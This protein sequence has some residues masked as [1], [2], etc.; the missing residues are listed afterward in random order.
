[1]VAV[2]S[3]GLSLES[4]I[5]CAVADSRYPLCIVPE[6]T[7]ECLIDLAN[8]RFKE[9]KR[10]TERFRSLLKELSSV[11]SIEPRRRGQEGDEWED[12]QRRRE[13]KKA[14][15]LVRS[16]QRKDNTTLVKTELGV[17]VEPQSLGED[18]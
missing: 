8:E 18:D 2:R 5:G 6:E 15:G 3:M 12:P 11:R 16:Q 17:I 1:M 4:I 13:R 10:R 7:L 9:N 14:D